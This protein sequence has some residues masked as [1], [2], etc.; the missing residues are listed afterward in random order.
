MVVNEDILA[1]H[2][3]VILFDFFITFDSTDVRIFCRDL[4]NH[5]PWPYKFLPIL[6]HEPA[7]KTKI[8]AH[9]IHLSKRSNFEIHPP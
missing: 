7:P 4:L 1:S 9:S 8:A 5:Q 2:L 3:A 6:N